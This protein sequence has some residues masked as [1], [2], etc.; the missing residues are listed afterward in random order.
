MAGRE[1]GRTRRRCPRENEKRRGVSS[2]LSEGDFNTRRGAAYGFHVGQRI[3]RTTL[4]RGSL[5]TPKPSNPDIVWPEWQE[6][7]FLVELQLKGDNYAQ[8]SQLINI[9]SLER[10]DLPSL[11]ADFSGL[12]VE[13]GCLWSQGFCQ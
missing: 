12:G 3:Q 11:E 5:L 9:Y 10:Q 6:A 8:V 7:G 4:R 13:P 2:N 1:I